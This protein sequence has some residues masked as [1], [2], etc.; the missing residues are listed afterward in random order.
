MAVEQIG[1]ISIR[2]RFW[3]ALCSVVFLLVMAISPLRDQLR[4]WKHYKRA[5]VRFAAG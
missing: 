1:K 3:F 2:L 5:Y 4:E